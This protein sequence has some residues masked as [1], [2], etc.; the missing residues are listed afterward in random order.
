MAGIEAIKWDSDML[1]FQEATEIQE[2]IM[3]VGVPGRL[4]GQP[5]I[6]DA[7]I[8]D[9]AAHPEDMDRRLIFADWLEDHGD[10]ERAEFIRVQC[11]MWGRAPLSEVRMDHLKKRE[12]EL[13]R[14]NAYKWIDDALPPELQEGFGTWTHKAAR[15]KSKRSLI[16]ELVFRGGFIEEVHA[17][18]A[19]LEERLPALVLEH[20]LRVVRATD[21]EPDVYG[22]DGNHVTEANPPGMFVWWLAVGYRVTSELPQNVWD[23]IDAKADNEHG[24]Y[25]QFPS[26]EAAREALSRALLR[27]ARVDNR[28]Q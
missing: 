28:R 5:T 2:A 23:A 14:F 8:A 11:E 24:N 15:I 21:K 17:R 4:L 13:I 22:E 10:P 18:L 16:H 26:L 20:P 12:D 7:F 6:C 19:V 27:L 1:S 25:K 9:I 3:R